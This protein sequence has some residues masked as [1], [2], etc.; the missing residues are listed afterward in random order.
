MNMNQRSRSLLSVIGLLLAA[1]SGGPLCG[2][3]VFSGPP[4]DEMVQY[5]VQATTWHY[6]EELGTIMQSSEFGTHQVA[7]RGEALSIFTELQ[8]PAMFQSDSGRERPIQYRQ[9]SVDF[10]E[11]G[12]YLGHL[13]G[14]TFFQETGPSG[15][16]PLYLFPLEF[17][18]GVFVT[19]SRPDGQGAGLIAREQ[20][21]D[22]FEQAGMTR[23]VVSE[24]PLVIQWAAQERTIPMGTFHYVLE[25]QYCS[26]QP[27]R[28]CQIR[29][30]H[31]FTSPT[32]VEL[33]AMLI[34]TQRWVDGR[35]MVIRAMQYSSR[36]LDPNDPET[37]E[38]L[39][40]LAAAGKTLRETREYVFHSSRR[41]TESDPMTINDLQDAVGWVRM[42]NSDLP[43]QV[44][45]L[46]EAPGSAT[47]LLTYH[48]P[49]RTWIPTEE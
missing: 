7:T 4:L 1:L 43:R 13:D 35:P 14:D 9:M 27:D 36:P 39:T 38:R 3:P 8:R 16:P 17:S 25:H 30:F 42:D 28:I 6:D 11:F 48:A 31:R 19:S 10:F 33:P 45:E 22:R 47:R 29:G 26:D 40:E 32:E 23:T 12:D 5:Q 15:H 21:Y 37:L 49:S 24:E 46:G 2:E 41:T 20:G 44:W 34:E 18:H